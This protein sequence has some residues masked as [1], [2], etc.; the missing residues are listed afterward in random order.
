ML[1]LQEADVEKPMVKGGQGTDQIQVQMS[2]MR[3]TVRM[4]SRSRSSSRNSEKKE[5]EGGFAKDR[6]GE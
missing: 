3:M 1:P 5:L 6:D 2:R 4:R